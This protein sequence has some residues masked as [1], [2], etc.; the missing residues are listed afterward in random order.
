MRTIKNFSKE[1]PAYREEMVKQSKTNLRKYL[2][3]NKMQEGRL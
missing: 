2:E 1:F 3:D